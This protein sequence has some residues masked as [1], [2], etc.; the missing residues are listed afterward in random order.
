MTTLT[1]A[2]S[3]KELTCAECS[4]WVDTNDF[5]FLPKTARIVS[6]EVKDFAPGETVF[7]CPGC[8]ARFRTADATRLLEGSTLH[9]DCGRIVHTGTTDVT[10]KPSSAP[11]LDKDEVERI[12]WFHSTM[13]KDWLE[14]VKGAGVYVHVGS[15]ESALERAADEYNDMPHSTADYFLWEVV[16]KPEAMITDDVLMDDNQW[17]SKIT[18]CTRK[19]LGGDVQRYL[20]R[21]EDSGSVSL[22]IDPQYIE[23]VKVTTITRQDCQQV[24]GLTAQA[25]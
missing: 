17:F 5:E 24:K 10:F 14:T 4:F 22:M 7:S 20:N 3:T 11:L 19:H 21:W 2:P 18:D 8:S 1:A 16:V 6:P 15:R 25:C 12:S 9:C 23:S 13:R